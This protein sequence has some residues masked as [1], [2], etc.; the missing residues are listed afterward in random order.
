M[1]NFILKNNFGAEIT[2]P[3]HSVQ[4]II[5]NQ[6]HY[7]LNLQRISNNLPCECSVFFIGQGDLRMEVSN[8]DEIVEQVQEFYKKDIRR[9]VDIQ[10]A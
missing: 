9:C 7:D 5:L 2:I 3:F 10:K 4:N 8:R 6:V 1:D